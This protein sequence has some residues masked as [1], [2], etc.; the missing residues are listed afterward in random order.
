Q[1]Q[2]RAAEVGADAA[3]A[4]Q[5]MEESR[6]GLVQ[7]V[8]TAGRAKGAFDQVVSALG[9]IATRIEEMAGAQAQMA[10]ARES[11]VENMRGVLE[12]ARE[13]SAATQELSSG[14]GEQHHLFRLLKQEM[15]NLEG[16]GES[17]LDVISFWG[18]QNTSLSIPSASP[19]D[20]ENA[21]QTGSEPDSGAEENEAFSREVPSGE[22]EVPEPGS[23]GSAGP[24]PAEE[25]GA[26]VART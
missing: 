14:F 3:E 21:Q 5:A 22:I 10:V 15:K 1:I 24:A 16:L 11:M 8:E 18:L 12:I 7:G 20:S 13:T 17:L 23:G 26:L 9:G 6:R 25:P 19:P 2:R 4:R